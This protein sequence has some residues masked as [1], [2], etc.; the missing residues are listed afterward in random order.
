MARDSTHAPGGDP[1]APTSGGTR[2]AGRSDAAA[3]TAELEA[4]ARAAASCTR[5]P[6]YRAA[7]RT[8]FG[9]G[10]V[11]ARLMLVGEQPGDREDL[12]GEPF[13]GPAGRLL[14]SVLGAAGIARRD[15]YV[16]N[17]VKHFKFDRRGKRRIHQRP[18]ASEIQACHTWLEQEL[19]SVGPRV[20]VCLGTTAAR[21]VLGRPTTIGSSRGQVLDGP[22]GLPVVVTIHPSAVLRARQDA[23]RAARRAGL[24]GDLASAARV[25][26]SGPEHRGP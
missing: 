7:T 1:A 21:A 20:V 25:A 6:L 26:A 3:R 22:G 15:V 16:T 18:A 12:E 10:R 9:E 23:D 11:G 14:D 19:R 5:C 13:V 4:A 17:A 8:V 24:V 2:P